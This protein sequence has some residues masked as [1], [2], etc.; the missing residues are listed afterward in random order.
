MALGDRAAGAIYLYDPRA[1]KVV[2]T[3]SPADPARV[4]VDPRGPFLAATTWRS[5]PPRLTVWDADTGGRVYDAAAGRATALTFS[6]DGK[7]L[8]FATPPRLFVSKAPTWQANLFAGVEAAGGAAFSP[9]NLTLAVGLADG[10]I[11]LSALADG[12]VLAMIPGGKPVCFSRDG[13]L[14]L[15]HDGDLHVWDLAGIRGQLASIGLDM[16]VSAEPAF[17]RTTPTTPPSPSAA[18]LRLK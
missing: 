6:P 14:L 13:T 16:H 9:D 12:R 4:A 8:A 11:R 7:H 2:F 15:T 3:A 5:D 18:D 1:D 17:R 10:N